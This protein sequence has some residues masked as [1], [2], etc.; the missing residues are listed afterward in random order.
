MDQSLNNI[1]DLEKLKVEPEEYFL[2]LLKTYFVDAPIVVVRGKPSLDEYRKLQEEEKHIAEQIAKLG[3]NCLEQK[4]KELQ[5]AIKDCV[6]VYI[7]I[8]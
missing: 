6:C 1:R 4:K 8:Y 7:H 2:H 3:I 5:Q